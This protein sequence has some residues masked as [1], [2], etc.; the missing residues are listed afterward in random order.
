VAAT[1]ATFAPLLVFGPFAGVLI[2]RTDRRTAIAVA[3]LARAEGDMHPDEVRGET[4]PAQGRRRA[5]PRSVPARYAASATWNSSA[6]PAGSPAIVS[7]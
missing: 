2:D 7:R 4:G 3:H 1:V 5:R 6:R